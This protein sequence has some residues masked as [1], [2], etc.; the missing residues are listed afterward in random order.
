MSMPKAAAIAKR[1]TVDML[2]DVLTKAVSEQRMLT[3]VRRMGFDA[4]EGQHPLSLTA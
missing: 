2:A 1:D 3:L 4:A